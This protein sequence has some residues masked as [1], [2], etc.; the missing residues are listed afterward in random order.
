MGFLPQSSNSERLNRKLTINMA[1]NV[2][3]S[4]VGVESKIG[5]VCP[6][7]DAFAAEAVLMRWWN[8]ATVYP[9]PLPTSRMCASGW[10]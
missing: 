1:W 5:K 10:I 3:N 8:T 4:E 6:A 9:D 7:E 2:G